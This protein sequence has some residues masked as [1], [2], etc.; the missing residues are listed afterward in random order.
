VNKTKNLLSLIA[1]SSIILFTGCGQ[2][3]NLTVYNATGLQYPYAWMAINVNSENNDNW[4]EPTQYCDN[5]TQVNEFNSLTIKLKENSSINI[6]GN[7]V[8]YEDDGSGGTTTTDFTLP[9]GQATLYGGF[10]DAP[11]WFAAVNLESVTIY[12]K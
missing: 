7:G 8:T 5:D 1:I 2:D 4:F 11:E 12:K 9:K 3:L 6:G 10:P